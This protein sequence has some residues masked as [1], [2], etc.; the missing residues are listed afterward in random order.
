MNIFESNVA[1]GI[2]DLIY[3]KAQLDSVKKNFNQIKLTFDN[4]VIDT[5]RQDKIEYRKF[6][7][8]FGR[9]LFNDPIYLL[10][11]GNYKFRNQIDIYNDY[12]IFPVIPDLKDVLPSGESLN[13]GEEYIVLN[14]KSRYFPL[15]VFHE[16]YSSFWSVI[17]DISQKYK[18]IILGEREV[19]ENK[20]YKIHG[21]N[22]I[23]SIY[24]DIIKNIDN[25][26]IIDMTVP[27]LGVTTPKLEKIRQDSLIMK[28]AKFVINL[29]VGG[30]FCIA[31]ATSNLICYRVDG[32][33]AA[34]LIFENSKKFNKSLVT[35][36][37]EEF[38]LEIKKYL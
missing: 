15:N 9:L 5:Y 8:D 17:R 20:E 22:N 21:K 33:L 2:G 7:N 14:T 38:F 13:I 24:F 37:I 30:S 35:K 6:L 16:I 29:G 10:N 18:I 12:G 3:I 28:E 31:S 32:D 34:D 1:V 25:S 4:W 23:Y 11:S 19:E 36:D 27:A 26:K